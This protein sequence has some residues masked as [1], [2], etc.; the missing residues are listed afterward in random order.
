[1]FYR[2]AA[3]GILM[4][5]ALFVAFVLFGLL[6]VLLGGIRRWKWVKNF[7]FRIAHLTAIAIVVL[8]SWLGMICPLTTW[9]MQLR[10]RAGETTYTDTF[11]SHWLQQLLFYEAP[12]WVFVVAYSLF[13][14]LV[15]ASWFFVPPEKS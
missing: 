1:M 6:L 7:W 14:G 9:E 3:D 8:Q 13:G 11:V 4:V 12:A 2:L 15:V 5:H 10:S